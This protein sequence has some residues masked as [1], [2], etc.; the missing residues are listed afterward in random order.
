VRCLLVI[1]LFAQTIVGAMA[2][3]VPLTAKD[4]GLM[5]R[6]GCSSEAVLRELSTRHFAG[7]FDSDAEQQLVRTGANQSLISALRSGAYAAPA[8]EIA[9]AQ[10]KLAA[11]EKQSAPTAEQSN[12]LKTSPPASIAASQSPTPASPSSDTIYRLLEH[13]L[14]SLQRGELKPFDDKTIAEKKLYLFFFSANTSVPARKFTP[15]LVEYYNRVAPLHPEFETIFFS[16]DRSPFGMETYMLQ[17]SMPWPAVVFDKVAT[18]VP[19]QTNVPDLPVLVLVNGSGKI[20]Y[21]SSGNQNTDPDK[22]TADLDKI[23][24]ISGADPHASPPGSLSNAQDSVRAQV[25]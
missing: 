8:S 19:V 22:V 24:A 5:L 7:N 25:K 15:P 23:L 10:E 17:T 12:K 21:S 9:A 2:G 14:V 4:I 13:D 18:K 6:S 11:R 1:L 20:L 16:K 3:S